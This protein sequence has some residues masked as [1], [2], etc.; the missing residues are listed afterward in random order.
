MIHQMRA[1]KWRQRLIG[2]IKMINQL[3]KTT[4]VVPNIIKEQDTMLRD[5]KRTFPE[6]EW[7]NEREHIGNI[8]SILKG[9][10][11]AN[12]TI[13]YAQ[14]I[15]FIVFILYYVYYNDSKEHVLHDTFYSLHTIISHI[16]PFIPRDS[17]DSRIQN[18]IDSAAS[19]IRLKFFHNHPTLALKLRDTIHIKLLIIQTGPALFANWFDFEDTQLIWDYLF[20]TENIFENVLDIIAGMIVSNKEVYL[21]LDTEKVLQITGLRSFYRVASIVSYA[22]TLTR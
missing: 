8:T 3:R 7:F 6:I 22:H 21:H 10:A 11:H 18:W 20:S 2:D 14:G 15:A 12:P 5:L 4:I 16:R 9:F 17:S 13:G 1:H 19:I